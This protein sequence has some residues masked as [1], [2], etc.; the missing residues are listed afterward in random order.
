VQKSLACVDFTASLCQREENSL[1]AAREG[2]DA[3]RTT[4]GKRGVLHLRRGAHGKRRAA[5]RFIRQS[6]GATQQMALCGRRERV[7]P[8]SFHGLQ[9]PAQPVQGH[10]MVAVRGRHDVAPTCPAARMLWRTA[11]NTSSRLASTSMWVMSRLPTRHI[12][13]PTISLALASSTPAVGSSACTPSKPQSAN[14]VSRGK[15]LPQE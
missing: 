2:P 12:R 10:G 11:S 5:D 15:T 9:H 6:E 1:P 14:Q 3:R 8:V 7:V 4:V 13:L